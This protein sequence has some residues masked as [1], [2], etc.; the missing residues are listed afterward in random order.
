MI[1]IERKDGGSVLNKEALL[2]LVAVA[3]ATR[4]DFWH[5]LQHPHRMLLSSDNCKHT[6]G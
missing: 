5:V 3:A 6:A 1:T 2:K 4:A